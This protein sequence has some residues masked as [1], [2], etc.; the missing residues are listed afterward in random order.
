MEVS[1]RSARYIPNVASV[2]LAIVIDSPRRA[3]NQH[4]RLEFRG[5]QSKIRSLEGRSLQVRATNA[6]GHVF[7]RSRQ[8]LSWRPARVDPQH[9]RA[10][11]YA[12]AIKF[13]ISCD[14]TSYKSRRHKPPSIFLFHIEE[15]RASLSRWPYARPITATVTF[16]MV[17]FETDSLKCSSVNSRV[18][19]IESGTSQFKTDS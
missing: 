11:F 17:Q 18:G 19:K 12:P 13:N 14:Y 9:S 3:L 1:K 16:A 15:L 4:R 7:S 2:S 6:H 8:K 5:S 10:S